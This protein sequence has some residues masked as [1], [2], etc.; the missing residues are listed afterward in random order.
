MGFEALHLGNGVGKALHSD[1]PS[2]RPNCSPDHVIVDQD[3]LPGT[4]HLPFL[5]IDIEGRRHERF[6]EV[7]ESQSG[8]ALDLGIPCV[9]A[10]RKLPEIASRCLSPQ[11]GQCLFEA[12]PFHP[13]ARALLFD[14]P[15]SEGFCRL[16][17]EMRAGVDIRLAHDDLSRKSKTRRQ[18]ALPATG[19]WSQLE[20]MDGSQPLIESLPVFVHYCASAPRQEYLSSLQT[21]GYRLF[22]KRR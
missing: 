3:L 21:P 9:K 8:C 14:E 5:P 2:G 15:D 4:D 6:P 12:L 1:P 11:E 22:R 19:P 10:R 17:V 16:A 20:Q 18:S 7:N 13:D